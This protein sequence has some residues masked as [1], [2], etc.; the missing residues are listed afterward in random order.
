[1]GN[2]TVAIGKLRPLTW[3]V[4]GLAST[5]WLGASLS[6]TS[7]F[8][9]TVDVD[10]V[11][12]CE[13]VSSMRGALGSA[14]PSLTGSPIQYEDYVRE[15]CPIA[16]ERFSSLPSEV[17]ETLWRY[18]FMK[19]T[20]QT[21]L[22]AVDPF[23]RLLTDDMTGDVAITGDAATGFNGTASLVFVT[24]SARSTLGK[25]LRLFIDTPLEQLKDPLM[26]PQQVYRLVHHKAARPKWMIWSQTCSF[27]SQYMCSPDRPYCCSAASGSVVRAISTRPVVLPTQLSFQTSVSVEVR[28]RPPDFPATPNYHDMLESNDRLPNGRCRRC[29]RLNQHNRRCRIAC[30]SFRD[31]LCNQTIPAKF[32]GEEWTVHPPPLRRDPQRLIPR[33]VHQTYFEPLESGKYPVLSR[34]STSFQLS[35]WEY[36]FY[37]DADIATFLDANFPPSVKQA[38]DSLIPGAFKADL[39]RYCVL[40]IHGGLYAD[41]DILLET[42]LDDAIAP[43]VGFVVPR[44]DPGRDLGQQMCLWNGFMA[45]APGHP[46]LAKTIELVVNQI[47]NRFTL[48]DVDVSFC[49]GPLLDIPHQLDILFVSGPCALGASVN[50]MLGR[51]PQ[52]GF[53]VGTLD[54]TGIGVGRTILLQQNLADLSAHRMTNIEENRILAATALVRKDD[55]NDADHYGHTRTGEIY[56]VRRVYVDHNATNED[57]AVRVAP[58]RT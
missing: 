32:V 41:V 31:E 55:R 13:L 11:T 58:V 36:R 51:H 46:Y 39:F 57:I 9:E 38:Y 1:M 10:T 48:M 33:I 54:D 18:C 40:L 3:L 24:R 16:S 27:S 17:A 14:Q 22:V 43:D 15:N 28:H 47:R 50:R 6:L 5:I 25:V 45:A 21:E 29:L 26:V 12:P 56:G 42:S 2:E 53:S 7:H 19:T 35:G 44:D 30:Q 8:A 23:S 52:A 34:L 37:T 20:L 4:M 49:P